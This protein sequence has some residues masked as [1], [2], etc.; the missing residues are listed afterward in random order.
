MTRPTE[1]DFAGAVADRREWALDTLRALV[2]EPTV[3]GHERSGQD[4]V[5]A[6]YEELG[7]EPRFEPIDEAG[8]RG[9]PGFGATDWELDG[10][11]NLVAVHEPPDP[12]GRSL[13]LNGHIDVVS[14]EPTVLWSTPPFEPVLLEDD[15]DG[16]TWLRGRGAGDMKGGTVSFL[17]ALAAL[18]DLGHVPGSRLVLQSPVEEECTGNGTLALLAAGHTADAAVIPEPFGETLT[19]HQV[20]VMWFDVRVLGRTTHVLGASRGVNAIEKSWV[21]LRALRALE[22]E[23]NRPEVIP[24]GYRGVEHPLNLNVGVIRGG[25]WASTVAGECTVRYRIGLFPGQRLDDLKRRIESRVAE[26][27]A[28][29]DWL[30]TSPPRVSYV[31]FQ[32]EGASFDPESEAGRA[33][34][35]AHRTW[36]GSAPEPLAATATTDARF[37]SLYHGIPAT[38]YGPKAVA[39]HGVDE[40]VSVDSMQRVAEVLSTFV[41]G[42]CGLAPR[43]RR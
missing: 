5:A 40:K 24:E 26:A 8:I 28:G 15:E 29:D 3:L 18:G 22:E 39:I 33:L 35:A 6:I 30:R 31:G 2:G 19:V 43:R 32:A 1:R 41:A 17:W 38:C 4:R 25:D 23:L 37:M 34:V 21:I 7:F 42:W 20:G 27:A 36:R 10:K 16:E 13:I 14:P 12:R 11:T 9:L